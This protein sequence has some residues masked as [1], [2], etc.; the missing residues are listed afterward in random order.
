MYLDI[1][2]NGQTTCAIVDMGATHNFIADQE[3]KRLGLILEKNPSRMKAVNSEAKQISRLAKGV[4]IKIGTW[5]GSTNMMSV[6]LDDFQVILGIV[7]IMKLVTMSFQNFLCLMGG[8][9]PSWFQFIEEELR[10]LNKY[11]IYNLKM[12]YEKAN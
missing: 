6:S 12:G 9:D 8:D 2:L 4:P 1:K 7:H 5:S 11:L 10:I 3:A